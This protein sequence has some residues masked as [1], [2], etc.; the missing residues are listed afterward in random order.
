LD[1]LQ[2]NKY[3]FMSVKISLYLFVFSF[4]LLDFQNNSDIAV[5]SAPQPTKNGASFHFLLTFSKCLPNFLLIV[6][7]LSVSEMSKSN[8]DTPALT[9]ENVEGFIR[10]MMTALVKSTKSSNSIPAGSDYEYFSNFGEF[11]LGMGDLSSNLAE[12]IQQICQVVQPS[13]DSSTLPIDLADAALYDL[14]VDMID[15]LLESADSKMDQMAGGGERLASSI[16]D[17]LKTDQDRIFVEKCKDMV[18]PQLKFLEEIDNSRRR[19]FR[20]RLRTKSHSIVPL[21]ISEQPVERDPDEDL[22]AVGPSTYF[23]HPY[24]REILGVCSRSQYQ[25]QIADAAFVG[26]ELPSAGQPFELVQS[27]DALQRMAEELDGVKE[28]AV[29]LEHHHFRSFLGLTCL[30][31]VREG[32]RE[33]RS[34][35]C[36]PSILYG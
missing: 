1:K 11:R 34:G 2:Q 7:S 21:D 8:N 12:Q 22:S 3:Y 24:S 5:D 18:K 14:V 27:L 31:Q 29:D 30:M 15:I 10:K 6:V 19:P 28:V 4:L 25:S 20:P 9:T 13:D 33:G 16:R 35:G 36:C 32:G 26:P 23:P 17:T